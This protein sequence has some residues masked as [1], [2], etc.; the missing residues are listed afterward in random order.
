MIPTALLE[1]V[2][3]WESGLKGLLTVSPFLFLPFFFSP[4]AFNIVLLFFFR[5]KANDL[6]EL[7]I[8]PA[9]PH[10]SFLF[11]FFPSFGHWT[12][13]PPTSVFRGRF[14]FAACTFSP[15]PLL[16][17]P[18]LFDWNPCSIFLETYNYSVQL[19]SFL[20]FFPPSLSLSCDPPLR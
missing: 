11:F 14:G 10:P 8:S 1:E 2:R 6:G 17:F 4:P 16:F 3:V 13:I 19:L 5:A 18:F 20:F 9:P 12:S 7:L 15:S